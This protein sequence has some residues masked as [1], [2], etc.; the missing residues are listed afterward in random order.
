MRVS[1]L[2]IGKNRQGVFKDL[3]QFYA[4][5]IQWEIQ[6]IEVDVRKT[7][8]WKKQRLNET[9]KLLSSVPK[10]SL[11]VILDESGELLTSRALSNWINNQV[12]NGA[13]DI[14]FLNWWGIRPRSLCN[15]ISEVNDKP[16]SSNLAHL[17]IRGMIASNYIELSKYLKITRIM[18]T[19]YSIKSEI[20][21]NMK[22]TILCIM[23]GWGV[24]PDTK[25][26][27]VTQANTPVLIA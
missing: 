13:R 25:Y 20:V 1:I 7:L 14:S 27:A 21:N 10:D 19:D 5:R 15:K 9:R 23:D 22:P 26:N 2:A 8:D 6:L 17:M 11:M 16:R 18:G 12:D 24:G 4:T 3:Y